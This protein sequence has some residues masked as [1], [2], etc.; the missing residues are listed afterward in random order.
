MPKSIFCSLEVKDFLKHLQPVT[1]VDTVVASFVPEDC[2]IILCLK[3]FHDYWGRLSLV[4][5]LAEF[6]QAQPKID[7]KQ[8]IEKAKNSGIKRIVLLGL[9]LVRELLGTNL[10]EQ[11]EQEIQAEPI[12][13]GL[14]NQI[15]Q[16]L[17]NKSNSLS[18]NPLQF[19][20]FR[21][22][23]R[24]RLRDKVRDSWLLLAPHGEEN[25][26]KFPW[27]GRLPKSLFFLHYLL[28]L[29]L[30]ITRYS[31][32]GLS[33]YRGLSSNGTENNAKPET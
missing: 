10:P 26:I 28:R 14:S 11:V 17:F 31:K 25:L 29:I 30:I 21:L 27:L 5:D 23:A 24:E 2:L 3:A 18:K 6:I 16:Q 32:Y 8:V 20:L 15:V 22:K 33:W 4:C 7:W 9:D 13:K 12:V 1:L 19:P